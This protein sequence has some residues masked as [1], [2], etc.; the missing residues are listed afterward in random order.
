MEG[1]IIPLA[2]AVF[3][4]PIL[5]MVVPPA[6]SAW[7]RRNEVRR[8]FKPSWR[9]AE[10]LRIPEAGETAAAVD[11]FHEALRHSDLADYFGS[12]NPK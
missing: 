4:F 5:F 8:G 3:L 2:A 1:F 11:R 12:V 7:R 6:V 10:P 9:P